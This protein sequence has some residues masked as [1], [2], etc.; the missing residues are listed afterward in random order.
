MRQSAGGSAGSK[1]QCGRRKLLC[2]IENELRVTKELYATQRAARTAIFEYVE[3]FY[4]RAHRHSTIGYLSPMAFEERAAH[5]T[6][7]VY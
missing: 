2:H 6:S 3:G 4:N 7:S 1:R 5:S